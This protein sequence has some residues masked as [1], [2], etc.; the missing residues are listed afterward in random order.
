MDGMLT[1]EEINQ[2]L[3][4]IVD[5]IDEERAIKK[6]KK[7]HRKATFDETIKELLGDGEIS[8]SIRIKRDKV[9][10][11]TYAPEYSDISNCPICKKEFDICKAYVTDE[12]CPHCGQKFNIECWIS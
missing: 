1:Q 8:D 4:V 11:I 6:E 3:S 9:I 2:L 12:R 10:D 7:F 5:E